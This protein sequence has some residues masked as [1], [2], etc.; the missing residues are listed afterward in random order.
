VALKNSL[1]WWKTAT[2]IPS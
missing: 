1:V 2:A